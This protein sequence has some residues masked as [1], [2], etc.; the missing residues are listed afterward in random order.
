MATEKNA[1]PRLLMPQELASVIRA[2]RELRGWS[3]ETLCTLSGLNVRTIQRI[4]CG[5]PS[6]LDTRRA[7]ARAFDIE[8]MDIFNNPYNTTRETQLVGADWKDKTPWPATLVYLS[9]CEKGKVPSLCT[10]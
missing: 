3:Q 5:Q 8:D 6:D 9:A 10:V 1:P 2:F 7:I 4:E